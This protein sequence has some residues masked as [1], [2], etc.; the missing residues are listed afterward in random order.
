MR[1]GG[2]HSANATGFV[3]IRQKTQKNIDSPVGCNDIIFYADESSRKGDVRMYKIGEVSRYCGLPVKTLRYYSEIGLLMPDETDCFTGYRYY[4]A[5]SVY[6]GTSLSNRTKH[7]SQLFKSFLGV[8]GDFFQKI[9]LAFPSSPVP[10]V[11]I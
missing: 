5:A 3:I 11:F 2:I 9:L 8:K 10:P 1:Q 6:N 4:S 7:N